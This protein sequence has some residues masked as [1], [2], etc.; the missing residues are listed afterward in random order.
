[1]SAK[2]DMPLGELLAGLAPVP[3]REIRIS[4]LALDSREVSPGSL[5][6]ALKGTRQHGL[7]FAPEALRRGA[8]A[9]LWESAPD[10]APPVVTGEVFAAEIA[11]LSALVGAIADRF[12]GAPTGHLQVTGITGTNGKTTCAWL[13]AGALARLGGRAVYLGTLG[14]GTPPALRPATHTTPDAISVHRDCAALLEQG[15]RSLCMEVSSHA[16]AQGRVGAVRFAAAA[17][18]NL[19]RDHLDYHGTMQAYGEAKALLFTHAPIGHAVINVGDRFG[20]DLARRVPG[21]VPL[22]R[23]RADGRPVDITPAIQDGSRASPRA[24]YATAIRSESGGLFVEFDG[25]FGPGTLRTPLIGRFNAENLLVVLALLLSLEVPLGDAIDALAACTAPPGRMQ[26]VRG[27]A[28]RPLA[29]I[30][31]AHTPDALAKVLAAVREH[32]RGLVWCVFGC[33]GDRDPGKRPLMGEVADEY[34]D[35]VILTDDNPRS[36]AP[37]AITAAI[38]S[39]MRRHRPSIINDRRE[40]IRSALSQAGARDLVLIA[41]KGHE[42]YQIHGGRRAPFSDQLEVQRHFGMAA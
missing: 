26:A 33:G 18:T 42:D 5:F 13:L 3:A 39:G 20:Q 6:F 25:S 23:V 21:S 31:Y 7:E 2:R 11:G 4:D 32:C 36:E 16:L 29:V 17:F 10:V 12:F 19:T 14:L 35:R 9:I 30:D 40:A 38:A 34:A 22:T 1:M 28:G 41:G 37:E 8:R 24:L 27:G 15:A